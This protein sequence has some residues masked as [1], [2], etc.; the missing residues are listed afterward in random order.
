MKPKTRAMIFN[1]LGFAILFLLIRF[2]LGQIFD[3]GRFYLALA[4]AFTASIL[5]P[6]FGVVKMNEDEK[7]LMKWIF[8]KGF[9]EV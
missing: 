1:F 9:R 4:A 5:A 3:I 7:V 8:I 2:A 6:K